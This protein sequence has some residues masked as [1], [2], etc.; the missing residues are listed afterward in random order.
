MLPA[1]ELKLRFDEHRDDA[2]GE[3]CLRVRA[4]AHEIRALVNVVRAHRHRV[5]AV[6]GG[7]VVPELGLSV[8]RDVA[9]HEKQQLLTSIY[10]IC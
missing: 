5:R 8:T 9:V 1:A 10:N 3:R 6:L 4:D 7:D 2:E